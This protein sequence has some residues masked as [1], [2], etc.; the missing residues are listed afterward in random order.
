MIFFSFATIADN[1]GWPAPSCQFPD[2]LK[3]ITWRDLDGR[4]RYSLDDRLETLSGFYK[5]TLASKQHILSE[6]RCRQT[7]KQSGK[8]DEIIVH[9]FTVQNW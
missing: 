1:A 9:S 8:E 6:S 3:G 7:L 2:W 4:Q 5:Q